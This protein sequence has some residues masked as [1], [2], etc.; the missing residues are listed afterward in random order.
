MFGR[1]KRHPAWVGALMLVIGLVM[2]ILEHSWSWP[3][4]AKALFLGT[5]L[6]ITIT[7]FFP[8][9]AQ[10]Q[11]RRLTTGFMYAHGKFFWGTRIELDS[12]DE[13]ICKESGVIEI[14]GSSKTGKRIWLDLPSDVIGMGELLEQILA[15]VDP[16]GRKSE[17]DAARSRVSQSSCQSAWGK[18]PG[19]KSR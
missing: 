8:W 15:R 16:D 6:L 2:L 14:L 12:I 1:R 10:L 19:V 5:G 3:T 18:A 9:I 4:I 11:G 13:I 17:F 7:S